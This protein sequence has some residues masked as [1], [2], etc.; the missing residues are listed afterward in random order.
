MQQRPSIFQGSN[1][2]SVITP[3]DPA[4][5]LRIMYGLSLGSKVPDQVLLASL[6]HS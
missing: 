2:T 5:Q 4:A 1:G 3:L 6:W